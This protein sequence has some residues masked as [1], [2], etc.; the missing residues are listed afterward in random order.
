[1]LGRWIIAG[2]VWGGVRPHDQIIDLA[3]PAQHREDLKQDAK[4]GSRIYDFI[5]FIRLVHNF[6][7]EIEDMK[8]KTIGA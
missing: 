6:I 3:P 4:I 5:K 1:M 7:P 8:E 2:S